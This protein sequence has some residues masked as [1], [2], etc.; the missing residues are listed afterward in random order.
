MNRRLF[1]E[2]TRT[3]ANNSL[4]SAAVA[5]RR[6]FYSWHADVCSLFSLAHAPRNSVINY[7]HVYWINYIANDSLSFC[8]SQRRRLI[9]SWTAEKVYRASQR[10]EY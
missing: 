9:A 5:K 2:F 1:H 10:N 6:V 7:A 8:H 4:I 3:N